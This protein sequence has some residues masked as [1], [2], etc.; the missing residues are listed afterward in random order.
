M[1]GEQSAPHDSRTVTT[2]PTPR[3]W[4]QEQHYSQHSAH[5]GREGG[6]IR[7]MIPSMIGWPDGDSTM[8]N[9]T[10]P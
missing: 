7:R 5:Y 3:L 4:A 6:T 1:T 8:R 2:S 10:E 9:M